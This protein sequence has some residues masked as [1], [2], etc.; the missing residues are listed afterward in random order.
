[1]LPEGRIY[2]VSGDNALLN[3][4]MIAVMTYTF[5]PVGAVV[6][7]NVEEYFPQKKRWRLRLREKSGKVKEMPCHL[8]P[9]PYLDAYARAAGIEDDR[10]GHLSRAAIGKTATL[11]PRRG[12]RSDAW[13]KVRRRASDAGI[14]MRIG[15]HTF[16]VARITDYLIN[17][18]RIEVAQCLARHA[19][20]ETTGLHD[21]RNHDISVEKAERI[22]L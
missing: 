3:P 4:A 17:G 18:A 22:G 2:G 6:G 12:L 16:R 9:E 8:S 21:R 1:M 11:P 10:K 5:A 15:C 14:E 19:N 20:V 13:A 7:W